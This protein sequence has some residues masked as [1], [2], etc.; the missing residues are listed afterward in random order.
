MPCLPAGRRYR[1]HWRDASRRPAELQAGI[2]IQGGPI[3]RDAAAN[4]RAEMDRRRIGRC[5]ALHDDC[6]IFRDRVLAEKVKRRRDRVPRALS[7]V[8]ARGEG[9]A[10]FLGRRS[11]RALLD[12]QRSSV[13]LRQMTEG[14]PTCDRLHSRANLH[15]FTRGPRANSL[16][17]LIANSRARP[18]TAG[19]GRSWMGARMPV[20][21]VMR[22]SMAGGRN[23][24]LR[25]G[26]RCSIS[27]APRGHFP[28]STLQ[29]HEK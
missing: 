21:S 18:A 26:R 7:V 19:N 8:V 15:S 16:I 1:T 28:R 27:G 12:R 4:R 25:R 14:P 11:R 5:V 20:R 22:K 10:G 13:P 29:E 24:A 17:D 3:L 23:D 6:R 9:R 2:G